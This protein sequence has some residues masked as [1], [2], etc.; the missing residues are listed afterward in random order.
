MKK[1]FSKRFLTLALA[2]ILTVTMLASVTAFATTYKYTTL[3]AG[4]WA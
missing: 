1:T 4:K 3:A 2:V